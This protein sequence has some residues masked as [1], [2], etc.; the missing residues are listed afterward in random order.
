MS[1]PDHKPYH[2]LQ[3]D[4]LKGMAIISVIILHSL[5]FTQLRMYSFSLF[6]VWQALPIFFVI[7]ALNSASSFRR[8]GIT[9]LRAL[10]STKYLINRLERLVYPFMLIFFLTLAVWMLLLYGVLGSFSLIS[11]EA[12]IKSLLSFYFQ[13]NVFVPI[14]FQFVLVFPAL[15]WLYLSHPKGA[16]IASFTISFLA[17][18]FEFIAPG[19]IV[20]NPW[21]GIL[22][23]RDL[24][25]FALGMWIADDQKISSKRNKWLITGAYVSIVYLL[26]CNL[27]YIITPNVLP[28]LGVLSID[29]LT[30]NCFTFFYP[31][32]L[33]L[34]GIN[35]LPRTK[36]SS[37]NHFISFCGRASWHIFLF[38]AVYIPT[39]YI[40]VLTL[41]GHAPNAGLFLVLATTANIVVCTALG[42]LLFLLTE[43]Y[44][45]AAFIRNKS[46]YTLERVYKALR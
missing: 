15:Y 18:L 10:Y 9:D 27:L 43:K 35:Y 8:K 41:W 44:L 17:F 29:Y 42:G 11:I 38:Q 13:A 26:T 20:A 32:L 24:F 1:V 12:V 7:L 19:Q 46:L 16:V 2:L 31:L 40:T 30:Q 28:A 5:P 39:I 34:I 23:F 37:L 6:Y 22:I 45:T 3:I 33:V 4:L 21:Y 25:I 36:R 14:V